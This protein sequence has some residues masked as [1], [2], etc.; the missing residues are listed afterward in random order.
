MNLTRFALRNRVLVL[1]V[2][3]ATFLAGL[4]TFATM[5]RREDPAITIRTAVI[6][7][8]W[9]GAPTA[10]IE[11]LVTDPIETSIK[12][13]QGVDEI[14]SKSRI[15]LSLV[16]VDLLES[17]PAAAV[18]QY[19]DEL[20]TKV[21]D[22]TSELPEGCGE[23]RVNTDFGDVYDV[24]L[25]LYQRPSA[26]ADRYSY[27][28]LEVFA[29][30][31]EDELKNLREVGRV[32]LFGVQDERIYLEVD[33]AEWGKIGMSAD[34]LRSLLRSRNIVASGGEVSRGPSRFTI[35]PTGEFT[36][37]DQ[38]EMLPVRVQD[39]EIPVLLRDLPINV[40]RDYVDP[41]RPH[42]R[43][44]SPESRAERALLIAVSMKDGE[45]IVEM[46]S[47]VEARLQ[48]LQASLLPPDLELSRVNDLPRQ[49]DVLVADFM[50]NLWQ[51]I[52]IVLLVALLMMGWR[53]ALI[54]AAAVPLCMISSVLL[55]SFLGVELEQFSIAS[56][57]IALGMLVDNAIVV[58]DNALRRIDADQATS[59]AA[60]AKAVEA[61]AW[62]L[63]TPL[64]TSTATTVSA[65]LPMLTIEGSAGE[66]MRSLPIVVAMTLSVSFVV[67]MMVTPIMCVWL[68]RPTSDRA[69]YAGVV[70]R[71]GQILGALLRRR[72]RAPTADA[73]TGAARPAAAASNGYDRMIRWCLGHRW[74][75]C[76]V[77]AAAVV[78]SLQ[79]VP[80]IGSEFF[81]GGRRDQFWVHVWLPE[82]S[83]INATSDA[84]RQ[85]EEII[86][87]TSRATIDGVDVERLK[88][89]TS[90]VGTG[91]PRL[92]LTTNPEQQLSNYAVVLVNTTDGRFSADWTADIREQTDQLPGV[93][94]DVRAF[95]LGP[96]IPNPVEFKLSGPDHDVL[97]AKAEEIIG[98]FRAA[99]GT[100]SPFHDWYNDASVYAVSI[101]EM[102]ANLAGVSNESIATTMDTMISGGQLTTF[103]EGDH[104][105]PVMLRIK[106]ELRPNVL[107]GLGQ[108]YVD[109]NRD[110]VPLE[111]VADLI[112]SREPACIA[113]V[114]TIPTVS[115]GS[116]CLPGY[117]SNS[118]SARVLPQVQAAIADLPASYKLTI[119]GEFEQ[120]TESSEKIGNA[121]AIAGAL[122]ILVLIAQYNSVIKPIVV[123]S[124]VPLALIGALVGLFSTGWALGFMPSLGIV[125]LAGVVINNAI[126]LIDFIEENVR[127]GQKLDDAIANAGRLR[128]QPIVLTTLTTIGGLLPLALLGGPMWAGMSWAMI[129]GL[130]LS[131]GLTLFV[132]PTVYGL[133]CD[134]FRLQT[135]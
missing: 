85:V 89:V 67:A 124:T 75:T 5:S 68:L 128:M 27:R 16:Y 113:R 80:L 102:T 25:A 86:L 2:V 47:A 7:T 65:F 95:R 79:L 39:D 23:P 71:L 18:D 119:G 109:G 82:G 22:A 135:R 106:K 90:I 103:R 48:R 81:P 120:T 24:V 60:R 87:A 112:S 63:S 126:V 15:G 101:D 9:P 88:S 84:A 97:R 116:Q 133:C 108:L 134:L 62:G 70:A 130:G 66:Y 35:K 92:N 43:H 59:A 78:A 3:S 42:V 129:F 40:V 1:C 117:L 37:V 29:E 32:D 19:F 41:M 31:I 30:T 36:S 14:R 46:G 118:V 56:L 38:I 53:P 127:E 10:K 34:Q 55:V 121:F 4:Y 125:S 104:L 94:I 83:S 74:L 13:M 26:P 49:V 69:P 98:I 131:T 58:S 17:V 96:Y 115:V 105:V 33:P 111:S 57:I 73:G 8:R 91:G 123:L 44:T 21:Q 61:G 72:K 114:D 99:E 64:L 6:T 45:N 54:M 51:A 12:K 100:Y 132:V 11:D 28:Q 122:I 77:A 76:G 50:T 20:R 52:L 93:R 107:N 110:K